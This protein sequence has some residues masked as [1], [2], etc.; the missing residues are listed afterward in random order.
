MYVDNLGALAARFQGSGLRSD[1]GYL[2]CCPCHTDKTPSLSLSASTDGK[3]LYHCYAGC[4]STALR[5]AIEQIGG[6]FLSRRPIGEGNRGP[7][8]AIKKL[9]II[10]VPDSAIEP[11]LKIGRPMHPKSLLHLTMCWAY[12]DADGRLLFYICRFEEVEKY[13]DGRKAK[14]HVIPYCY[15]RD[16]GW[17]H[18][19]PGRPTGPLYGLD[20]L[21][22]RPDTPVLLV[23]GEKTAEAANRLFPDHVA[24]TWLGGANRVRQTDW[25]ALQ[26]REVIYWPDADQAGQ[27]TIPFVTERL[28]AAR[29]KSLKIVN[30]PSELP[31]GWDLADVV[32]NQVNIREVFEGAQVVDLTAPDLFHNS[33]FEQLL[34]RLVYN[35]GT[36]LFI[37]RISGVRITAGQ[38]DA[39]FRHKDAQKNGRMSI[40]L[41]ESTALTKVIGLCYRPGDKRHIITDENGISMLNTW[42]GSDVKPIEGD[43]HLFL[44]HLRYICSTDEEFEFLADTLAF[45]LQKLGQKL[46]FAPVLIGDEG[47]G[48]SYVATTMRELLGRRD[49]TI[50]TTNE[51]RSSFN[52]WIAEKSLVIVE[53]IMAMGRRELMNTMKP[54]ITEEFITVNAK[55]QR[56]YEIENKANFILLSNHRDALRLDSGD[57]RYFVVAS[58]KGPKSPLYYDQLYQWTLKNY[59]T[60]LNW[61]LRR[62]ISTFSANSHPPSTSGKRQMIESSRPEAELLI[63]QLID[64]R[65]DPFHHNLFES[66]PAYKAIFLR[67]GIGFGCHVTYPKFDKI[68]NGIGAINLGQQ[69]ATVDGISHK[70]SLWAVRDQE[71]Y[72]TASAKSLIE[73]YLL[74]K[75]GR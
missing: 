54:L 48:K 42:R 55:Y 20:R 68:M 46:R 38:M 13:S 75:S 62:D 65:E 67:D 6:P 35:N 27:D 41:L 10:P 64:E 50:T 17:Q 1:G 29:V 61:L 23:E 51:I 47:T 14:K 25:S 58:E 22:K 28:Q 18:K 32:P 36:E 52:E 73:E 53:E 11:D 3:L 15:F 43:A 30:L 19:G 70:I 69:K 26:N 16:A 71:K 66:R 60:I 63:K 59:G 31:N 40:S 7:A 33:S 4:E 56:R 45:M 34:K 12:R 24:I 2:V 44:E 49:T 72:A 5:G 21:S 8:K 9:A 37:D 74:K 39:L 57:R